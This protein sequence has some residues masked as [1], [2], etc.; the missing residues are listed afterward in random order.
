[1]RHHPIADCV[2]DD[3]ARADGMRPFRSRHAAALSRRHRAG[4]TLMEL[5]LA[6]TLG[7][8]LVTATATMTGSF[9]DTV[10][11][12]DMDSVDSYEAT[13][14]RMSRDVRYA[15]WVDCPS[16]DVL[17]IADTSNAIT[18]YYKVGNSLLVRR[19]DGL[20]GAVIT[21]LNSVNFTTAT[22]RRLREG[23]TTS[24]NSRLFG[25][26]V[27]PTLAGAIVMVQGNSLALAF[28]ANS[29]VGA[30]TA[31]GVNDR[32]LTSLPDRLDL[33][34]AKVI[35]LG[36]TLHIDMYPSR[37]I[38]DARPR[39]GAAVLASWSV[40]LGPLPNGVV[41][42][43]NLVPAL[44]TYAAPSTTTS[45]AIPPVATRLPPG[46]GY[47]LVLSVTGITTVAIVGAW[48]NAAGA[49]PGVIFRSTAGG[50]WV[51]KASVVPMGVF[52][53]STLTTTVA[54]T[55]TTQV[56]ITL[57]DSSGATHFGS[58][59]PSSQVL[60][61]DPWLGVVPNESPTLP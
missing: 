51:D 23:P 4:F 43:A 45:I 56:G 30:L 42:L 53:D 61:E 3:G 32:L 36:G 24:R 31:S 35:S 46:T 41:T 54:S 48:T 14:A 58:A 38:G 13:I 29:N 9:G 16:S 28:N 39:P 37:A 19:P 17:R 18:Q 40:P 6:A 25:V 10:A 34:I 11:H 33:R 49:Q 27:P 47:S 22:A 57:T 50:A 5:L 55:V 26:S 12:L 44:A 59:C 7:A 2:R 8:L 1:M 20:E 52:G 60:A 21:G 15:W